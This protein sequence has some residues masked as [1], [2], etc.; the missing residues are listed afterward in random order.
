MGHLLRFPTRGTS[1]IREGG[2][3]TRVL[4]D[5]SASEGGEGSPDHVEHKESQHRLV[6][7]QSLISRAANL[8]AE[9]GDKERRLAWILDDCADLL[10]RRIEPQDE[11]HPPRFHPVR[12]VRNRPNLSS[13][14]SSASNLR[15]PPQRGPHRTA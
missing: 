3:A 6:K 5:V 1:Q 7:A 9:L 13:S 14:N 11:P 4:H 2:S 12:S 8:V 15:S 10:A